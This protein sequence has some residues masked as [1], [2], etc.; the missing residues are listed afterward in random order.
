LAISYFII[1]ESSDGEDLNT[2]AVLTFEVGHCKVLNMSKLVEHVGVVIMCM[3][4]G[5]RQLT[6]TED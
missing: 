4:N 2:V 3:S 6:V 5:T 1:F